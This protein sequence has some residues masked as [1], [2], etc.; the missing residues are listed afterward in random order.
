LPGRPSSRPQPLF[1]ILPPDARILFIRLRSMGD[2]LLLTGPLRA[3]RRKYP[4]FRTFVLVEPAFSDCYNL[5]PDVD[6]VI[7]TSGSKWRTLAD[8]RARDFEAVV[9]LHGGPTSFFMTRAVRAIRVGVEGY[10]YGRFYTEL[11][12]RS[13]V[14]QHTVLG[15]MEFFRQLGVESAGY[16]P[17]RFERDEEASRWIRASLQNSRIEGRP[18]VVVHPAALM[19]TKRW[20][21]DRFSILAG[22][23]Q[24][25]GFGIVLTAGPGEEAV[26]GSVASRT[27]GSLTLLGLSIPRL[28]ELIREAALYI[29]N[30]S[31]PMHLA[32]AV[33]TPVIV[34][35]GS[36]DSVR[37]RPWMVEHRVVQNEFDC[38]PCPG[39]K[40][41][42]A[43]T[44]L[45]I[46]SVTVDQVRTAV[47]SVLQGI[48]ENSGYSTRS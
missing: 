4:R 14:R 46:E 24:Q 19:S 37:W 7:S 42:V 29:G 40:C 31:G 9:N 15:T 10:P 18:Y 28:G 43:R 38:N 34:P 39:Y 48:A 22:T 45:C 47:D 8:L 16:E 6:S 41:G 2:C 30:D 3:L 32:A 44:P 35:W 33:G 21:P 36:S 25:R 20:A 27:S 17:L 26:L 5:N 12:E 1:D 23:L 13:D 11:L